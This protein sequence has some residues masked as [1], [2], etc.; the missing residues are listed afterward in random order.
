MSSVLLR[1]ADT[2]PVKKIDDA[3]RTT[4]R[5][6]SSSQT[7]RSM[8]NGVASSVP[9]SLVPTVD[10]ATIGTVNSSATRKRLR[11]SRAIA[12]ID[13]PAW[14]PWPWPWAPSARS[15]A[16]WSCGPWSGSTSGSQRW[17]GVD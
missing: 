6:S 4:G 13:I 16:A 17:P 14:P 9:S 11:M 2:A 3:Q 1:S 12:S 15:T 7:S 5:L 8:P 10:Q